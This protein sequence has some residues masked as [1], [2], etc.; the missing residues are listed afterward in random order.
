MFLYRVARFVLCSASGWMCDHML[1]NIHYQSGS[2]PKPGAGMNNII[3]L[4]TWTG[5]ASVP[6]WILSPIPCLG[7]GCQCLEVVY[8][9]GGLVHQ[10]DLLH[11]IW[12]WSFHGAIP[13][14]ESCR[15]SRSLAG[16]PHNAPSHPFKMFLGL[17]TSPDSSGVIVALECI[18]YL[19]VNGED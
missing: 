11:S 4:V 9:L 3:L 6:D 16:S 14:V 1:W 17:S 18:L 12:W 19:W 15:K 2:R 5:L 7:L 8:H 10:C 13:S